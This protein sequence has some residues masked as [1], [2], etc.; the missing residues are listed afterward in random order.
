MRKSPEL[1]QFSWDLKTGIIRDRK[2]GRRMA[3]F[4]TV[5][6]HAIFDE[7]VHELGERVTDTI[8]EIE[9]E[10]TV[11]AMKL[12]EAQSGY[13]GLRR[14]AALRGM[15]LLTALDLTETRL[16]LVMSNPSVPAYIAGLASGIFEL[17]NGRRGRAEWS[18][19]DD[20]DLS[21]R[22]SL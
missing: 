7:L 19:G 5:G 18:L 14:L 15:G 1:G 21:V 4:G 20:G 12:E 16:N 6:P 2:T 8:V 3:F 17:V 13:G 9:R 22:M 11:S 10:N